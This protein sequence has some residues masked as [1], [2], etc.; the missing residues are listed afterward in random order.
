MPKIAA[1]VV[2]AAL[3][4]GCAASL[5]QVENLRLCSGSQCEKAERSY[6]ERE[7]LIVRVFEM[8]KPHEDNDV[9]ICEANPETRE[10]IGDVTYFWLV[11]L[12]PA[13]G[14]VQGVKLQN[15]SMNLP[16]SQLTYFTSF[17]VTLMRVPVRCIPAETTLSLLNMNELRIES[18]ST[19]CNWAVIGNLA[20][21]FLMAIDHVDFDR[22]ILAGRYDFG[23][24]GFPPNAGGG[25]GYAALQFKK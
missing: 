20:L 2:L 14:T 10:C 17:N 8:L 12:L 6:F 22:G 15:V 3:L 9:K 18:L 25:S 7:E 5:K 11:G 16:E 4:S 1:V 21:T 19:Y 23:G 13:R 24:G